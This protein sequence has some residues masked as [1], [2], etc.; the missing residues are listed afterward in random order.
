MENPGLT[1]VRNSFFLKALTI[2]TVQKTMVTNVALPKGTASYLKK[3]FS[4]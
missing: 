3:F 1:S 2:S 4:F